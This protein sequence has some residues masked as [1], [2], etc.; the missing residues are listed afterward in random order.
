MAQPHTEDECKLA[1]ALLYNLHD[2]SWGEPVYWMD[3]VEHG[4]ANEAHIMRLINF[5]VGT[6]D[7]DF[8]DLEYEME[9]YRRSWADDVEHYNFRH[10]ERLAH[11]EARGWFNRNAVSAVSAD[12]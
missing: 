2:S 6:T 8:D 4:G 5:I 11:R 12:S 1:W 10:W 9:A 3:L 7:F